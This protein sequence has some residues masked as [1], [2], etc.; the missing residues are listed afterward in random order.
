MSDPKV[1]EEYYNSTL[2]D[3]WFF[4]PRPHFEQPFQTVICMVRPPPQDIYKFANMS[5][6]VLLI[7]DY[8][9]F[10]YSILVFHFRWDL[11]SNQ[12]SLII[13]LKCMSLVNLITTMMWIEAKLN[14]LTRI[15]MLYTQ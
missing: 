10:I 14:M 2:N 11:K 1:L 4:P 5:L 13:P 12:T 7:S 8:L 6:M 9:E 3:V 15:L